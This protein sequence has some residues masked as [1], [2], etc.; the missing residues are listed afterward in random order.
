MIHGI[1]YRGGYVE[2]IASGVIRVVRSVIIATH[3][4]VKKVVTCSR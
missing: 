2:K 4:S 3:A 1:E